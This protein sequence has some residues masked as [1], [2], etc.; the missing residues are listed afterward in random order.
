MLCDLSFQVIK[1]AV[2]TDKAPAALGPYSQAI[3]ANNLIF[4]SGVLGLVPETGKFISDNIEDQ[5]EQI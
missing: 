2:Q 1:E 5:M 4:V 3:K